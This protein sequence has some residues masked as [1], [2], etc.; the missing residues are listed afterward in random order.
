MQLQC[1]MSEHSRRQLPPALRLGAS[2][3]VTRV[4]PGPCDFTTGTVSVRSVD[5][6]GLVPMSG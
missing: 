4:R 3:Q 1:I 2:S 6:S 5:R